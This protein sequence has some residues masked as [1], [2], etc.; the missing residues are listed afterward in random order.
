[1]RPLHSLLS[2]TPGILLRLVHNT[3]KVLT[4][5]YTAHKVSA[6]IEQEQK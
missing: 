2:I 3:P 5:S 4:S 1:M 6:N